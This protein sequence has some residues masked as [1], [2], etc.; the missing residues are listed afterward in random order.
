MIFFFHILSF[1]A[2]GVD[3][4]RRYIKIKTKNKSLDE[5][6]LMN[7]EKTTRSRGMAGCC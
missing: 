2:S 1:V 4:L 5:T 6:V 7:R 3:C